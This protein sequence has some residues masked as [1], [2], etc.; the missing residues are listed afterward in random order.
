MEL[1]QGLGQG[2]DLG[3]LLRGAREVELDPVARRQDHSSV[4]GNVRDSRSSPAAQRGPSKASAS[5][6]EAGADR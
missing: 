1:D 4:P 6:T 2:V 3:D 5:R